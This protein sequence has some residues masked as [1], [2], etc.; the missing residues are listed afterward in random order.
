MLSE[1]FM[2]VLITSLAGSALAVLLK[3][4]SPVTKKYFGG[5]WNYYIWLVVLAVL[6]IPVRVRL[7]QSAAYK[8]PV[9][10]QTVQT[11][12]QQSEERLQ[13]PPAAGPQATEITQKPVRIPAIIKSAWALAE[14]KMG[15]LSV[16]W[17]LGASFLL[18]LRLLSYAVFLRKIRR[19]TVVVSCPEI[20]A[21]T[22]RKVIVRSG[23]GIHSP[24]LTGIIRPTLL[25]PER[26]LA[27]KQLN[28]VLC[29]EMTH[30]K[31]KDVLYKWFAAVVKCIHWFNPI[32]WSVSQQI[33][34]ECEISCDLVVVE[35]MNKEEETGYVDTILSLLSAGISKNIP[36]TT[37]MTGS[38]KILKRRFT[39]IKNKT[40][41]SK[42]AHTVSA[43]LAVALLLATVFG[44]GV[45]AN[46]ATG[47]NTIEVTN[48]GE[49]MDLINKPYFKNG[50]V[51][52][53]L[54][55]TF[56]KAG[57]L[58]SELS[59][60][61]WDNGK[62]ELC[63]A[64]DQEMIT[65]RPYYRI[66][67]GKPELIVRPNEMVGEITRNMP[68]APVLKNS[69]T[70][71]PYSYIEIIL[72]H[73]TDKLNID[74]QVYDHSGSDKTKE[75]ISALLRP[76]TTNEATKLS[77]DYINEQ[78]ACYDTIK[79]FFNEFE[80]GKVDAM[81]QYCSESLIL[82][83]FDENS[84]FGISTGYLGTVYSIYLYPDGKYRVA[85]QLCS[86]M[87]QNEKE[88]FEAV[89]EKQNDGSLLITDISKDAK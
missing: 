81:K 79:N 24:L 57:A 47:D 87:L 15:V 86:D 28:Y 63:F 83:A 25:L 20:S 29:H 45:L 9:Q 6:V 7:P 59:Y 48:N 89:M 35:N 66:E 30:L 17:L 40:K 62:I 4:I 54:R 31:R 82:R 11:A 36:L 32:V 53:P 70:Y 5:G 80:A 51:Y 76:L 46:A 65:I 78:T 23:E 39:M 49:K 67:I 14:S 50:E 71:I 56:E 12:L 37:G 22:N 68:D 88:N 64:Y 61:N 74:Y 41:I 3:I 42:T 2:M 44:G 77:P 75:T 19:S 26:I 27:S 84:L 34:I 18:L 1:I 33:N 55:E 73:R 38:K 10:K 60:I 72:N 21:F 58:D 16:V 13:T 85:C 43:V 8:T 52:L 69:V